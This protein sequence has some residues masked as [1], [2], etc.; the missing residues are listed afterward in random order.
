MKI[1]MQVRTNVKYMAYKSDWLRSVTLIQ[2][3]LVIK[4]IFSRKLPASCNWHEMHLIVHC[5]YKD[6]EWWCSTSEQ[7]APV[8]IAFYSSRNAASIERKKLQ[9]I[10]LSIKLHC[11]T[12]SG[13][14]TQV[15]TLSD[16][17]ACVSLHCADKK[18]HSN[19]DFLTKSID[20]TLPTCVDIAMS[21]GRRTLQA[22]A[23]KVMIF[24][25]CINVNVQVIQ[26]FR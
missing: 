24:V 17:L 26:C 1:L 6:Q 4:P 21:T 22:R 18:Q 12:L 11:C 15:F 2:S 13:I 9:Y 10:T 5:E 20:N 3:L 19:P 25:V 16:V 14:K 8:N 7:V 23:W